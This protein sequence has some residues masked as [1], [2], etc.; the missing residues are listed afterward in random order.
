M[1]KCMEMV[2]IHMQMVGNILTLGKMVKKQVF[3]LG[4]KVDMNEL[5]F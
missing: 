2:F 1:T 4:S 3:K 5:N